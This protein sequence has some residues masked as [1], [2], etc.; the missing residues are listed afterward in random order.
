MVNYNLEYLIKFCDK[1]NVKLI[2]NYDIVTRES[3]IEGYCIGYDNK[4][5]DKT[6]KKT[7][8]RMNENAG[9]R[10]YDCSRKIKAKKDSI[11]FIERYGVDHMFKSSEVKEQIKATNLQKYGVEIPTQ[12]KIVQ[13][14]RKQTNLQK[15]GVE[16]SA[17]D[18]K[19]KEKIKNTNIEKY[20]FGCSMQNK[21]VRKKITETNLQ[22]YGVEN[23]SQNAKIH[24]KKLITS[25]GSKEYTFPSGRTEKV[26]G[27][28]MYAL[29]EL[30]KNNVCED[31]IVVGSENVPVCWWYDESNIKHRYF[32]DIFI[33]NENK[34]IEVKSTYTLGID[35]DNVLRKLEAF[36]SM[37][38]N[39]EIWVYNSKCKKELVIS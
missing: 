18:E 8:R 34:G 12:N 13:E 39:C 37:G 24:Q 26:Q 5:C 19:I 15:Y 2:G 25:F 29:N 27:Y 30:I 16:F 33:K 32:I 23:V 36:K 9:A 38:Y 21:E 3:I 22:K 20:G 35:E 11:S 7:F 31:E 14:K 10:C 1:N 28:E 6:F 17:Q 4:Q